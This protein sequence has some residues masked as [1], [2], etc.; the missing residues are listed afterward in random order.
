MSR[1]K[2]QVW[3]LKNIWYI[4]LGAIGGI[5]IT[6]LLYILGFFDKKGLEIIKVCISLAAVFATFGGA[7]WG[8]K[9]SGDNALKL[10]EKEINYERKKEY[11]T[12]H[13]KMLSDLE[14]KGLNAIKQDLKKWNN[15]LLYEEDQ[16]YV[17]VF[18]IKEILEQIESIYSEV[19]F[20]DKICENKFKEIQKNIKDVKRMEWINEIAHD[21]DESGKEQVNKNLKKNKH[22]IFRL[23][24]KIGYSLDEIPKYDIYELEKGLR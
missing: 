21:L 19:E 12:D 20:T 14:S 18:E 4:L 9:I 8:A 22:E 1:E 15:N 7:Y 3:V 16:V 24:K 5:G 10:K 11:I 23:I 2:I 17:C 13:H 6:V